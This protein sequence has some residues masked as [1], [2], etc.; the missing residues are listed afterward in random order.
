MA[1]VKTYD[2]YYSGPVVYNVP[3]IPSMHVAV[4]T[5]APAP[6]S[7][8]AKTN[9]PEVVE[10]IAE[11]EIVKAAPV[12]AVPEGSAAKV[13]EWVGDSRERASAA[14]AAEEAGQGRKTLVAK[15]QGL[16]EG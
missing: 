5:P 8:E 1:D 16:L 6:A 13:L 11:P 14:L 2:P 3:K 4:V 15:L 10:Q 7:V 12:E 9:E